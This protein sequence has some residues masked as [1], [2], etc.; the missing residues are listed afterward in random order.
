MAEYEHRE[1]FCL[2]VYKCDVCGRREV[3]WN[4][5]DGVTP[6]VTAC[7]ACEGDLVHV[8]WSA[9]VFAPDHVPEPGQGVWIDMPESLKRP[10]A[11]AAVRAR[12]GTDLEIRGGHREACVQAIIDQSLPGAPWLIYWPASPE[13]AKGG[14]R[15]VCVEG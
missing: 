11:R 10:V 8:D 12:D 5:R 2:M 15:V 6:F 14:G 7:P 13:E 4:S 3:Y 9:D 1:A